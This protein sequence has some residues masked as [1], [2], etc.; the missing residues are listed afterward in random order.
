M[1]IMFD[2]T[3]KDIEKNIVEQTSKGNSLLN[4]SLDKNMK[5]LSKKIV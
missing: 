4:R 1:A 3:I 2:E 5:D